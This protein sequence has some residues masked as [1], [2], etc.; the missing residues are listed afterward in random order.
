M[1]AISFT[2][3][4]SIKEV[5]GSCNI[6]THPSSYYPDITVK[7]EIVQMLFV[8]NAYIQAQK[9]NLLK[10]IKNNLEIEC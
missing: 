10:N 2:R 6:L 5:S 8:T 9:N 7:V 3:I 4:Y 1:C